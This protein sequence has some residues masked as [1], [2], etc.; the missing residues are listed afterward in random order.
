MSL[1][2]TCQYCS[3]ELFIKGKESCFIVKMIWVFAVI[4]RWISAIKLLITNFVALISMLERTFLA[5]Y[6]SFGRS[7]GWKCPRMHQSFF[8]RLSGWEFLIL[9]LTLGSALTETAKICS[10]CWLF[11]TFGNFLKFLEIDNFLSPMMVSVHFP[12]LQKKNHSEILLL[13]I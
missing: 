10:F 8:M 1:P 7:I 6:C 9:F 12:H 2:H 11:S 4:I 13:S 3:I 5:F